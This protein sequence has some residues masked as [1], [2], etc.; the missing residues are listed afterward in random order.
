M[1]VSKQKLKE[2][3]YIQVFWPEYKAWFRGT[4]HE[5]NESKQAIEILYDDMERCVY[6]EESP[7]ILYI[8]A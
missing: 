2:G 8:I 4:V 5:I 6:P 7:G 3:N 1:P